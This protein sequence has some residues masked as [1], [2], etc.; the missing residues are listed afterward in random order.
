MKCS[1][2]ELITGEI[3]GMLPIEITAIPDESILPQSANTRPNHL[4]ESRADWAGLLA[5]VHQ[6]RRSEMTAPGRD[7]DSALEL[8]WVSEP[9]SNQAYDAR[10]R[11]L[12]VLRAIGPTPAAVEHAIMSLRKL[13]AST[14]DA[15]R[16]DYRDAS[17]EDFSALCAGIDASLTRAIVKEER[18]ESLRSPMMPSYYAFDRFPETAQD[19][20]RIVN[21]MV[22]HPR[23]AVSMQL[24]PTRYSNSESAAVDALA[25]TL[26]MLARGIVDP[27]LGSINYSMAEQPAETYGY[28]AA[29]KNA[30]LFRFNLVVSGALHAVDALSAA[31]Y[32]HLN[33]TVHD[34]QSCVRFIELTPE[35]ADFVHSAHAMPWALGEVLLDVER[36]PSAQ[37]PRGPFAVLRRLPYVITAT[38]AAE[39]FRLP[40]GSQRLSAGLSVN[41]AVKNGK[42]YAS[43]IING[44]DMTVGKLK[45]SPR[46]DTVGFFLGDLTKHMLV[47]GTPGS[48]K[49]TFSIGLLDRL[50]K[51]HG[52]PFLVIE[53]A[54]NEYRAL[55]ESIPDLQ[56]FTPGKNFISPFIMNPFIPPE[57]VTLESYK[58][59]LKT[60]FGA[61]VTMT[62]PL[63]RIF[64]ESVNNAYS[65]NRW[66]DYFTTADSGRI[67]TIHDFMQIFDETFEAIGYVGDARNIGR[68]GQVRL[69]S[70]IPLFDNMN[71][72]PIADILAKPTV[73]ELAAI[74][75][76]EQ[77]ALIIALLLLN[78]LAYVNRNLVGDGKLKNVILLEEAHVLLDADERATGAGEADPTAI[79]KGL[80]KRML[81]EIRAYGVGVIVADQSPRSVSAD[82]VALTNIKLAFRLVEA[83]DKAILANSSNMSEPQVERLARL[84][85]G[86]AFL[87]FD[88]LEE[89]EE[90]R[91]DDYRARN[92]IDLTITDDEIAARS[93][94]WDDK[95]DMLKPYP[96]CLIKRVCGDGCQY[97]IRAQATEIAKRLIVGRIGPKTTEMQAL[98]D[99]FSTVN[100]SIAGELPPGQEL[101]PALAYCS[102]VHLLRRV[103]YT[104]KI[105]VTDQLIAS[106]LGQG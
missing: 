28:Y 48:G 104:S 6:A 29:N 89:P 41:T 49:T 92:A 87:F 105:P 21:M 13:V 64:E 33:G 2:A 83:T 71:A 27:T 98:R 78:I 69:A 77:K 15:R 99:V 47:V 23:C 56:V 70:L 34:R 39:L 3:V 97:R 17:P 55:V 67:F 103:K 102:K 7:D 20:S 43:R 12:V 84:Q 38:E 61:A 52:I 5:E 10:I 82:V 59:T 18:V 30:A 37:P 4:A 42:L 73:V 14:L 35:E 58:S 1:C 65:R 19:L 51:E 95:Q 86:E 32:G 8:L 68:A 25:D 60:V 63:D 81:A 57:N 62:T 54:K 93:T 45:A 96:E 88:K 31:V 66:M 85:P 11:L 80:V 36:L 46:E 16:Y 100:A 106:T 90:V 40:I 44:G 74:E 101:T 91:T 9:V 76:S 26:G 22:N 94:Y 24:V 50:W 53:P 79:S 75:N 72:V